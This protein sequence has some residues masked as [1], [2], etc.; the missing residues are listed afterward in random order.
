MRS[1]SKK[2]SWLDIGL[3]F[4]KVNP[5]TMATGNLNATSLRLSGCKGSGGDSGS[6]S[7]FAHAGP[8]SGPELLG[9]TGVSGEGI[10]LLGR[11]IQSGRHSS[12]PVVATVSH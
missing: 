2:P 10:I 12:E 9:K 6:P 8:K 5:D 3:D 1:G 4:L 7:G 11:I